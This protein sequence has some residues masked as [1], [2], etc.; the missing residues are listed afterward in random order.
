MVI[1]MEMILM[2]VLLAGAGAVILKLYIQSKKDASMLQEKDLEL[3]KYVAENVDLKKRMAE[4]QHDYELQKDMADEI[5]KMREQ[6]RALKH[7][8]K[9]HTLVI[10][11][12]LEKNQ[13]EEAK[14]YTSEILDKLNA[15]YTYISVGNSLLNFIIN[16]KLS[17]AKEMKLE[18]KAEIENLPFSYM[19]SIDFSS[20]LNNIL[21]N[22]IEAAVR[23]EKKILT[24]TI[25]HKKGF[26]T[27][28]V[29]NSINES[30]LDNNPEFQTSKTEPGHGL[31]MKQIRAIVEKYDGEL[32]IYEE[33]GMFCVFVALPEK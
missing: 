3:T 4:I 32:D 8:M 28:A 5:V 15:M 7:D 17:K 9:N 21:D 19:D 23:S 22:A 33:Q 20:L 31:G 30:V 11:S 18:I 1:D 27:I 10:L 29:K 6:S 26:D 14:Q 13:I 12:Y 16:S 25:A 24:V 2:A